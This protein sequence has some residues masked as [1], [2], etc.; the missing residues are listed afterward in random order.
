MCRKR[1][2]YLAKSLCNCFLKCKRRLVALRQSCPIF[3]FQAASRKNGP[4]EIAGETPRLAA[5]GELGTYS[6]EQARQGYSREKIGFCDA[7]VRVG[8]YQVFL[9][10]AN[11]GPTL[12]QL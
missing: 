9:G 1:G 10:L 8:S 4:G 12:Q 6:A 7:D 5:R 11:I 2:R 3:I